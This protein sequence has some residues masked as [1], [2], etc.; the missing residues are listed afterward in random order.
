MSVTDIIFFLPC[1]DDKVTKDVDFFGKSGSGCVDGYVM[2]SDNIF[3]PYS[4]VSCYL[5]YVFSS[6]GMSSFPSAK[7]PDMPSVNNIPV[8]DQLFKRLIFDPS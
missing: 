1:L 7:N 6:I 8:E 3:N 2:I 4:L 5:Y